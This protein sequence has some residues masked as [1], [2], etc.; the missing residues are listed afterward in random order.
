MMGGR[1]TEDGRVVSTR[2]EAD[3]QK[4][5]LLFLQRICNKTKVIAMA[6][7]GTAILLAAKTESQAAAAV[8]ASNGS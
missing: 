2:S 5:G 4:F 1:Y 8:K 7:L 6:N 3:A